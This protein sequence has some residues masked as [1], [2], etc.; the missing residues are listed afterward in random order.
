M[1]K[2]VVSGCQMGADLGGI[3]AAKDC[4]F[5]TGGY[6]PLGYLTEDGPKPE[7]ATLYNAV[8]LSSAN[9]VERT[10]KN[11]EE[12][13]GTIRFAKDFLSRGEIC[14]QNA[15][16]KYNKLNFDINVTLPLPIPEEIVHW[17]LINDIKTLNIAGNRES[18]CPGIEKN[19]YNFLTKVFT[20]LKKQ[21]CVT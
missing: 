15:L 21:E 8:E 17:I 2:L 5:A 4:G 3:K 20:L 11:V 9:Y 18:V 1:L 14:T 7:Y 12:S 6:M 10:Y 16:R 13:D 19:V